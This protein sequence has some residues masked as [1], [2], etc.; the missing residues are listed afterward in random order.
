M[1]LSA[2]HS[3]ILSILSG[4]KVGL[5]SGLVLCSSIAMG[6]P[7]L[8]ER[9][10]CRRSGSQVGRRHLATPVPGQV[11]QLHGPG[12]LVGGAAEQDG[13]GGL[14]VLRVTQGLLQDGQHHRLVHHEV[15]VEA[16]VAT[17]AVQPRAP[18]SPDCLLL[19]Q[20]LPPD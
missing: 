6:R 14:G 7:G 12:S 8:A 18:E 9:S 1:D 17:C 15:P 2:A 3:G 13:D 20:P 5:D 4:K 16:G 10:T 11:S 19:A